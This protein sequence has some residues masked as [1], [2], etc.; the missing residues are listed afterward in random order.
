MPSRHRFADD[1]F[2]PATPDPERTALVDVPAAETAGFAPQD[3]QWSLDA[4]SGANIGLVM[5]AIDR[6]GGSI[7]L[8][9]GMDLRSI[10]ERIDIRGTHFSGEYIGRRA[11]VRQGCLNHRFGAT[12]DQPFGQRCGLCEEGKRPE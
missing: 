2:G 9:N 3:K 10:A 4:S 7:L 12:A 11:P 6:G 5:L 8:A 1:V